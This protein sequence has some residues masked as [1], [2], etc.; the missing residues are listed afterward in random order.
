[1]IAR[2]NSYAFYTTSL[3]LVSVPI[4][5]G[6]VFSYLQTVETLDRGTFQ[7]DVVGRQTTNTYQLASL[8]RRL[9]NTDN[10]IEQESL[11]TQIDDVMQNIQTI[12]TGLRQGSTAFEETLYPIERPEILV[13][14]DSM[15]ERW[16][17]YEAL[18]LTLLNTP[19]DQRAE[20][21][22]VIDRESASV[23]VFSERL[24][25]AVYFDFEQRRE[26]AFQ[27]FYL[28]VAFLLFAVPVSLFLMW[29]LTRAMNGL[30][31]TTRAFAKG[32]L[33]ARANTKTLTEVAQVA[34]VLNEMA[35]NTESLLEKLQ[36][37]ID[38]TQKARAEAERA[39]Q[40]KSAFLA[41]MSHELRTPL[42]A[43]INFTKFV[44][45]GVMGPVNTEQKDALNEVIDSGTHL[46]ALI[47]DVLDMSKIES[48]TLNLFVEDDIAI[49][50]LL[51]TV[52]ATG[53]S[54]I[55]EKPVQIS[56]DIATDLP[57]IRAD[58]QRVLQVLLNIISNAAKFTAS[59]QITLRAT[60]LGD[61]LQFSVQDTGP[62]IAA[63]DHALVFEPFQQTLTGLRQGGGTGL[64][65][66]IT[67][68]LVE[69]HQGKIWLDSAEGQG[70]TF[71]VQLP[72]KTDA[73]VPMKKHTKEL[74]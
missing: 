53:K 2:I 14:L 59:G 62:G 42:N 28:A 61:A 9:S 32:D 6:V 63:K 64:G 71:Y 16:Q 52:I 68:S 20:Q 51:E 50:P 35:S 12:Q 30:T 3:V 74:A 19:P 60:R 39:S 4:L 66:P 57:P 58:R 22:N 36:A 21:L 47:N 5:F 55:G 7:I 13:I 23:A 34:T 29:N 38:E 1:M 49:E 48:G 70:A 65:M 54:L 26:R 8:A 37:E 69:A 41:S 67:K 46:L 11:A 73:L 15:D 43:V 24:K 72:I 10:A 44:V 17:A 33:K 18:L 25:R 56:A 45:N 31:N 27:L 40:V